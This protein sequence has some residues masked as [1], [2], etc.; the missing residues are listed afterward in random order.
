VLDGERIVSAV[1]RKPKTTAALARLADIERSG[2]ATL[3]VDRYDDRDW[4]Q[5]WWVRL[6]G[7]AAVQPPDDPAMTVARRRLREKYPQYLES[8]PPG[9]TLSIDVEHLAWWRASP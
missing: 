6:S 3:L 4:S 9:P 7:P 1:D 5:L 2:R 8:P